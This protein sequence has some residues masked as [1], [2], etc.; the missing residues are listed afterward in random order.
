MLGGYG[1]TA[2][3]AATAQN[4]TGVQAITPLSGPFVAEQ[5]R[6]CIRDIGVD[7]IKIGMLHDADIIAHVADALEEVDTDVM[8]VL[9]PVML[10]TSGAAL[11]A[12][13][14][15]AA[16]KDLLF[17]RAN[18]VTPN[19][20]ELEHLAGRTLRSTELAEGAARELGNAYGCAVLAKG[21]HTEDRRII[22]IFIPVEGRSVQFDHA[23]IDTRH[24]HGT[25]C[26]LSSAIAT[27]IAHG[28]RLEHAVRLARQFV[29]RAIENA[30]SYGTGNGPLGHQAVRRLD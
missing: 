15:I 30:P 22:D 20:P 9:D 4:S 8:L 17:P 23:R 28:Q 6:S 2:I 1:M 19:L 16:M 18:L 10:S 21:G 29:L 13:D 11:I 3:T 24:T 5:V 25:G 14:A 26:T 12:P 7:A 27:L